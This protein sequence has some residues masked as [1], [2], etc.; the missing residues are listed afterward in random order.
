MIQ[1]ILKSSHLVPNLEEKFWTVNCDFSEICS[2]SV[3]HLLK[4]DGEITAQKVANNDDDTHIEK[5]S[6]QANW[7]PE[8]VLVCFLWLGSSTCAIIAQIWIKSADWGRALSSLPLK[9]HTAQ[10]TAQMFHLK[11]HFICRQND[12]LHSDLTAQPWLFWHRVAWRCEPGRCLGVRWRWWW[13]QSK[14]TNRKRKQRDYLLPIPLT[15]G[16]GLELGRVPPRE[17]FGFESWE[18]CLHLSTIIDRLEIKVRVMI[19]M[20]ISMII[21]DG[22][23]FKLSLFKHLLVQ[24]MNMCLHTA[25][26]DIFNP[27]F[28]QGKKTSI[29]GYRIFCLFVCCKSQPFVKSFCYRG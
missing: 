14:K 12:D 27:L 21:S 11:T 10:D 24:M 19:F 22:I 17:K 2:I 18:F 5:A 28:L 16:A 25:M 9:L 26:I 20:V 8:P 1:E 29:A 3:K 7:A 23:F 15:A 4:S 6:S 13:W